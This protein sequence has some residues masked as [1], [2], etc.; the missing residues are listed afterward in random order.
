MTRDE[1]FEKSWA[2]VSALSAQFSKNIPLYLSSEFQEA[3]VRKYFLDKLFKS[4]GWDVD[5]EFN[6]DPYKREVRI[7]KP[8]KKAHGRADYAFSIAPH[9]Q[10]VRFFA[11][12]KRPLP[13]ITTPDN[14]FQAIRYS[15]PKGLPVTI[16]TDFN[17]FHVIDS[18]F[19][20][21]INSA[22][23]RIVR[24]W[25]YADYQDAEKFAEIYYLFSR[26]AVAEG[27]LEAFAQNQLP[28][29]KAAVRQYT[30]F[31]S[32]ARDFDEDFLIQLDEW[33][34]T[35]ASTFKQTRSDMTGEQLT[36]C[37]QRTLDRLIFTR[38][39]EDKAIEPEPVIVKFGQGNKTAWHDFVVASKRLNRTYNGIV[40]KPHSIL[41]DP[42]FSPVDGV[43][44][45]IC[46]ELTDSHS[47]YN[48]DSIP[49][50]ILGRVYERFLGKVVEATP[51]RA[52]VVEKENV[53]K[54]GGVYYTPEYIVSYMVEQSL[55]AIVGGKKPDEILALRIIDTSCGS[56]SFLVGVFG[57]LLHKLTTYWQ[58]QKR[59]PNGIVEVR[60]GDVH[61]T[62][63]YKRKILLSCI[64]GVDIDAQA[65]EVAQLSLYLKLMEEET[66]YSAHQQQLEISEALLPSLS[67]NVVV[68]NSLVT[69]GDSEDL[70]AAGEFAK[71]KALNFKRAFSTIFAAGG[72]DLVIG[73]PPYIKE[74][75][76]RD[77]FEHV[78]SSPYYQGKM[79]IWY[80]FACRDLDWL[81]PGT[82][83]LAFIATNNW[84]TNAGAKKLRAKI[85]TD[86]RIEQLIDFGDYK[87]FRD[88]GIQTMI[89]IAVRDGQPDQYSFDYRKL[90]GEKKTLTDAHGLLEKAA[91]PGRVYLVPT[92]DRGRE[93]VAPLTFSTSK[94]EAVLAK[95]QRKRNF[96]LNGRKEIAQGIVAPQDRLNA[97]GSDRLGGANPI[98]AGTG[99]FNLTTYEKD[100][101]GLSTAE[102]ALVKPFYT[103]AE[104]GR[105][106]ATASNSQ[107]VIYTDSSFKQ[108]A[109]IKPYPNLKLH[110]DRFSKVITSSNHPY[111]L[112]RARDENFFVG[113]KIVSLRK[114]AE[115]TFT[116]TDFPC[117]VSQSFNI[118]K[119][120][121]VDLHFLTGL[122]NSQ[123]VRFW[124]RNK[125]KMQGTNYQIDKEP[126]LG[127]P[128]CVPEATEQRRLAKMV[129]RII[130]IQ[131]AIAKATTDAMRVQMQRLLEQVDDQLQVAIEGMYGLEASDLQ[132]M[133]ESLSSLPV[134]GDGND[135]EVTDDD[136]PRRPNEP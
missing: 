119:T 73:N 121:R 67:R 79:D 110:L 111:G 4:L 80:L 136:E 125:G 46:D 116:F 117:Y 66:T 99:I 11:E 123:V 129:T 26:A 52:K 97:S 38:F 132:I 88:A 13:S 7:E 61:L 36:E 134:A 120:A 59:V 21:N 44:A 16:L 9:Y 47:P 19:R 22:A 91:G 64:Y 51:K 75:T 42:S 71:V 65:V 83:K 63:R 2:A 72:F 6:K 24:S 94:A 109:T 17:S 35:L 76:N 20:P 130:E 15:W 12:A 114:C 53:R 68:G 85:T 81:K 122:L 96:E 34:L 14:C 84:V 18:R 107:W 33:R 37:V 78:R 28:P 3:E 77:A 50:E 39:L 89:L 27:S 100:S 32:E 87:V 103:S 30:L 29:V 133:H 93:A 41:D 115:P 5:H 101:L 1:E 92:F 69:L 74:Y 127:I 31:A 131:A 106:G 90:E 45:E 95:I 82:G 25:S 54:A 118:I 10:R 86:A 43:F 102:L 105:Y 108:K 48:F 104:L 40:F 135:E 126:L 62:L 55:Q 70:F 112:H 58:K 113:E 8:E 56:G 128:L 60:D 98:P 57:F 23:S 124:L 49:V